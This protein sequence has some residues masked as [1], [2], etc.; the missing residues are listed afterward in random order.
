MRGT[1]NPTLAVHALICLLSWLH[2]SPTNVPR[3]REL[4]M[5]AADIGQTDATPEEAELLVAVCA[6]ES[7]CHVRAVGDGGLSRGAWQVRG[8]DVSAR[9]A[10]AKLRWSMRACGGLDIYAGCG[11]CGRCPAGLLESLV[12]PTLPRR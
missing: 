8:R 1:M 5:I 2:P 9:S 6:H 10:L 4:T 7:N 11:G 3:L 12:D